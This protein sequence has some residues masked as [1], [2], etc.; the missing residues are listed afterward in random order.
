MLAALAL[1]GSIL[2]QPAA[3]RAQLH[4]YTEHNPPFNHEN[5]ETG[6]IGGITMQVVEELMRRADISYTV[7]LLPWNRAYALTLRRP[8]TCVFAMNRTTEREKYFH[9]VTPLFEG[10]WSF[11]KRPDSDISLTSLEDVKNYRVVA[12]SGY[13]TATALAETGHPNL[14]LANSNAQ[15][16]QLL[17]HERV[18]LMLTGDFEIAYIAR[19]ADRPIPKDA[20]HFRDTITGMGCNLGTDPELIARLQKINAEMADFRATLNKAGNAD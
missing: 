14:L 12:T 7:E 16:M 20:L 5:I 2:A 19:E 4:L 17:Y 9:W 18:D 10:D 8:N 15:A 6:E 3:E 1:F 11:F 13:A